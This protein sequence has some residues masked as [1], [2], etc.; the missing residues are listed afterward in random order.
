LTS[1][2]LV[3][4]SHHD[5][6]KYG[7]HVLGVA[8]RERPT[9]VVSRTLGGANGGQVLTPRCIALIPDGEQGNNSAIEVQQVAL[10]KLHEGLVGRPVQSVIKVVARSRGEPSYHAW[11]EGVSKDVLVDLAASTPKLMVQATTV[12]G[13]ESLCSLRGA[14]HPEAR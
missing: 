7:A 2:L 9:R 1:W 6:M 8:C 13:R 5:L 14:A 4:G 11:V 12:G 10:T 3:G